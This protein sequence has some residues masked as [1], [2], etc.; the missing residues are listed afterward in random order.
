MANILKNIDKIETVAGTVV[1]LDNIQASGGGASGLEGSGIAYSTDGTDEF[2]DAGSSSEVITLDI[3]S[4]ADGDVLKYDASSQTW[5]NEASFSVKVTSG[6]EINDYVQIQDG[7]FKYLYFLN[8]C[9]FSIGSSLLVD[10]LII[11][12]GGTGGGYFGG[13]GGA[14]ALWIKNSMSLPSGSYAAQVAAETGDY[15]T[16]NLTF[17]AYTKGNSS[18]LTFPDSTQIEVYGGGR[19][20]TGGGG[21]TNNP[22]VSGGS[23]GGGGSTSTNIAG[24][25]GTAQTILS[26][27]VFVNSGGN[28]T[29]QGSPYAGGGGGGAGGNGVN[30]SNGGAGKMITEFP[31]FGTDASNSIIG[32]GVA[33]A[34]LGYYAGGGG[35]GSNDFAP[36]FPHEG[37]VGGGGTGGGGA[38]SGHPSI[39]GTQPI[40]NTGGGGG[41][42]KFYNTTDSAWSDWIEGASGIIAI[43]WAI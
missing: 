24:A 37:G 16:I 29:G 15:N 27:A 43:R 25:S 5:K 22:A 6:T 23:G 40:P 1:D 17:P 42:M 31:H 26:T 3:D 11:G 13:G 21:E 30:G 34:N 12:G 18:V 33:G 4:P 41:G 19:G 36:S 28:S 32:Q 14:G 39:S 2:Y 20:A 9:A 7:A 10:M 38:T 35:A 8:T